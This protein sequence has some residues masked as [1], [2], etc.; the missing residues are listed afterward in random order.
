MKLIVGVVFN[1]N[2]NDKKYETE[3]FIHKING[4]KIMPETNSN[5]FADDVFNHNQPGFFDIE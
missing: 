3:I 5:V 1:Y 2:D 4:E